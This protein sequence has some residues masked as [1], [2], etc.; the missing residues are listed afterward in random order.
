VPPGCPTQKPSVPHQ[1]GLVGF[2][3]GHGYAC[4]QI[5]SSA[6]DRAFQIDIGPEVPLCL[7][8]RMAALLT[9]WL[10]MGPFTQNIQPFCCRTA[11]TAHVLATLNPQIGSLPGVVPW[12]YAN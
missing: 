1:G 9:G 2:E 10:L 5:C 8:L 7:H 4:G 12:T 11:F 6:V 3:L